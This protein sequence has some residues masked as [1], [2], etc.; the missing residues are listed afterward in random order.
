MDLGGYDQKDL[1]RMGWLPSIIIC[2][3][4][5]LWVITLFPAYH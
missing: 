3:L 5:V 4:S 2:V 1:L